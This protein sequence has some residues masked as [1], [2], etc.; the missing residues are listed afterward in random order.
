MERELYYTSISKR[1]FVREVKRVSSTENDHTILDGALE[2]L[3]AYDLSIQ[4]GEN[5]MS[6]P[7]FI[8]LHESD[9]QHQ[10]Q[11]HTPSIIK[12]SND[13]HDLLESKS[14][15]PESALQ[16]IVT[17][18]THAKNTIGMWKDLGQLKHTQANNELTDTLTTILHEDA[19]TAKNILE[20]IVAR[21]TVGELAT[22]PLIG[23]DPAAALSKGLPEWMSTDVGIWSLLAVTGVLAVAKTQQD[24]DNKLHNKPFLT[25]E[26]NILHSILGF[27]LVKS[28][29][30]VRLAWLIPTLT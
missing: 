6:F 26:S 4:M 13:L 16:R 19:D 23:Q 9:I 8:S 11:V 17:P 25:V 2:C 5:I 15:K 18:L 7:E 10:Y 29:Y 12:L 1:N 20:S 14:Q 28:A 21:L 24:I 27:N 3:V 22:K 30:F